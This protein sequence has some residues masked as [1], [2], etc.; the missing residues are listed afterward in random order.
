[1][2]RG[3][4][5]PSHLASIDIRNH[6]M[7]RDEAM[8]LIKRYEGRRPPSLDLFLSYVGLTEDEFWQIALGH[9]VSPYRHDRGATQPGAK[10]HDFERWP[11]AGAMPGGEAEE[12][13][14]RWRKRTQE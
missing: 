3:Y 2:K 11:R 4:S 1:V 13:L 9:G 8:A 6:R 10:T 12:Q 5:R 7:S 14:E